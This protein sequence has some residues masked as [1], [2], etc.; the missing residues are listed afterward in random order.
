ML[1]NDITVKLS[2]LQIQT[3]KVRTFPT[4]S[5][6][7]PFFNFVRSYQDRL[8]YH[9][10]NFGKKIIGVGRNYALHAQGL[11]FNFNQK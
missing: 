9:F 10:W 2:V 6:A 7:I 1:F 4:K 8:M 3:S 5:V 11:I